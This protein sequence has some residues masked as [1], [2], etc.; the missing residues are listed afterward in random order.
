MKYLIIT[1]FPEGEVAERWQAF[2]A[3][4]ELATHYTSP[5]YFTD[6]YIRN[7]R[8]AVA[9]VD[10]N[11]IF[12]AVATGVIEAGRISSGMFSRPQLTFRKG[13][14]AETAAAVILEGLESM[15]AELIDLYAWRQLSGLNA[16][17][18][19]STDA[20]SVVMLDLT[21]GADTLF[22][23]FSQTRRN[24]L[25][26]AER[27][28]LIRIKELESEDELAEMY[29]IHCRWNR[30]K[31]HE[32]DTLEQ[33]RTALGQRDNR[34]VFIAK[35]DGRVVAGSFYRFV[36]GGVVEYAANFSLPEFQ[37]LRPNDVIGWHAIRWA[38][39]GGFTHFSM[40]GSHLFLRRFGGE[41]VRTYRYRVDKS[42]FKRHELR[43]NVCAIGA[44]AYRRLP[45]NVRDRVNKILSR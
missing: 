12:H 28:G 36:K 41:I 11:G 37:R 45:Q 5:G 13:A 8:F 42:L 23:G 10:D 25:R 24:E 17:G 22:A 40:G 1:R 7:E 35:A 30:L 27:Q 33:M 20:T 3:E 4:A 21:R 31:G 32:P 18:S 14:D 34:R 43:E 26:K 19:A 15:D 39:E 38:C 29:D 9:A 2:L 6:P 16:T 44:S